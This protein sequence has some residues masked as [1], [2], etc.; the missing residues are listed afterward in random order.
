[1]NINICECS[2]HLK[3]LNVIKVV[4]VPPAAIRMGVWGFIHSGTLNCL[5]FSL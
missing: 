1:M 4:Q 5:Q 2:S 3:I